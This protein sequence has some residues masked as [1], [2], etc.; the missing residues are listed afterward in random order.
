MMAGESRAHPQLSRRAKSPWTGP[1]PAIRT[2]AY[3]APGAWRRAAAASESA[4]E[5]ARPT[6]ARTR[7]LRASE[8]WAA[9]EPAPRLR[10]AARPARAG[11][12]QGPRAA[13]PG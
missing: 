1:Q 4:R 3:R 2:A 10:R 6:R 11:E 7:R 5:P 13:E 12:Q 9:E 8:S